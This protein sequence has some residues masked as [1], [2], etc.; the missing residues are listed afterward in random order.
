MI[1]KLF[2]NFTWKS[3]GGLLLVLGPVAIHWLQ[4]AHPSAYTHGSQIIG[5]LWLLWQGSVA[6][7]GVARVPNS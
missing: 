5:T 7:P 1:Q 3:A 6:D 4:I 2:G